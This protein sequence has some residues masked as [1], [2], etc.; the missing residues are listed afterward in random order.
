M[1][2]VTLDRTP[3]AFPVRGRAFAAPLPLLQ[4]RDWSRLAAPP[5]SCAAGHFRKRMVPFPFHCS[6]G[7]SAAYLPLPFQQA[8]LVLFLPEIVNDHPAKAFLRQ[9]RAESCRSGVTS[10]SIRLHD[11]RSFGRL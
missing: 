7:K 4:L 10:R 8:N 9:Q 3:V 6:V 5:R 1:R 11:R 2:A